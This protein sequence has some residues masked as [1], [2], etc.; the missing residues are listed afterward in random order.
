M[1]PFISV[2]VAGAVVGWASAVAARKQTTS[3]IAVFM[4]RYC[5]Y[6]SAPMPNYQDAFISDV[7]ITACDT[8]Q[9]S[10]EQVVD[11][12][13]KAGMEIATA[14]RDQCFIEGSVESCKVR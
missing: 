7:V 8:P 14:N 9:R 2:S 13:K 11:D 6:N 10:F 12:L 3:G 5:S 1:S 4:M